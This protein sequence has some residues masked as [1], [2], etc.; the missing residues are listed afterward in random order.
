MN[1][2]EIRKKLI[3]FANL[4]TGTN[5]TLPKTFQWPWLQKLPNSSTFSNGLLTNNRKRLSTMYKEMAQ[6]RQ[7][8]D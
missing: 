1:L 3:Q 5:T 8:M 6:I 7:A 4:A 2:D